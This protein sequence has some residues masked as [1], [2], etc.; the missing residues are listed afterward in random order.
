MQKKKDNNVD[1]LQSQLIDYIDFLK[2]QMP[3]QFQV[4]SRENVLKTGFL[5]YDE[6]IGGIPLGKYILISSQEGQG[7]TTLMVQLQATLQKQQYKTMYMDTESSMSERRMRELGMSLD[8]TIYVVPDCLE[9]AYRIMWETMKRKET[10]EDTTP[11]VFCFDSNTATPIRQEL[12]DDNL[13]DK[14]P[15]QIAKINSLALKR[16]I[17]PLQRTNST[18]IMISQLREKISMGFGQSFGPKDQTTGGKQMRFYA[19]QDIVLQQNSDD[20]MKKMEIDGK[21]VGIKQKKN[22]IQSPNVEFQLQLD[23]QNGFSNSISNFVYL[24]KLKEK[25]W[26]EIGLEYVPFKVQGGWY[27]VQY[28]DTYNKKFR[29][30]EFPNLYDNDLDFRKC[31]DESI[32]KHIRQNHNT[33]PYIVDDE[34]SDIDETIE[35][36]QNNSSQ[37]FET[38]NTD[39]EN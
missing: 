16:I 8:K 5:L 7:K 23:F 28:E 12:E 11:F 32:V 19:H 13:S 31:I 20:T 2:Q 34:I 39:L 15:G 6:I 9:D 4:S 18:L 14:Q 3:T 21:V 35:N 1:E 24:S 22:R 38:E 26:K 37:L 10:I 36:L 33:T 29:S 30:K 25:D 17:K 27:E